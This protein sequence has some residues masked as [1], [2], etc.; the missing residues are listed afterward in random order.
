MLRASYETWDG[1][2]LDATV[3]LPDSRLAEPDRYVAE[4]HGFGNS[5]YEY[6]NPDETAYTDNAFSWARRGYAVLTYTA[7]GP[8]GLV[9]DAGGPRGANPGRRAPRATSTSPTR[10]TRCAILRS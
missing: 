10:A 5:K 9:R 4:I 1:V 2:P 3:T 8:L 7:R 6:L